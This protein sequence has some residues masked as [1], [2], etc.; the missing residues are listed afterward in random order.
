M[1]KGVGLNIFSII[2]SNPEYKSRYDDGVL[3]LAPYDPNL[4]YI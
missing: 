3:G 1:E 4:Y 2:Y